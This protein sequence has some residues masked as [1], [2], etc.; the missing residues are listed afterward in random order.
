[1]TYPPAHYE[2]VKALLSEGRFLL[3]GEAAFLSLR[4]NKDF[5]T[6]FFH[7]SFRLEVSITADYA[8]LKSSKD[9]DNV[10]RSIC[11]YL[12][13]LCYEL[14]HQDGNLLEILSFN[15][16]SITEWEDRF[17]Q[18]SYYNVMEATDRLRNAN[19]RQKFY[20]LLARRGLIKR[21][22]DDLF[23]FT[24]AHRYFLEYARELNMREMMAQKEA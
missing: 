18:S 22:D 17:E 11:V 20:Q 19:Q 10:A 7:E 14:D 4:E 2:I 12:A 15:T 5:Y 21:I 6:K 16:F 1:M 8:L 24:P 3:E 9:S 13:I 23:Q